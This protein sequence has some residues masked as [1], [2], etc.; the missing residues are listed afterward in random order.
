MAYAAV[1]IVTLNRAAENQVIGTGQASMN[2]CGRV[3]A[4]AKIEHNT[5]HI[6]PLLPQ[7][8]EWLYW[9]GPFGPPFIVRACFI[10]FRMPKR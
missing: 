2:I 8:P 7:T 5:R 10:D 6:S 1:N 3:P 9:K 4:A